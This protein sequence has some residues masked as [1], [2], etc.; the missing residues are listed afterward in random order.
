MWQNNK[1]RKRQA[2]LGDLIISIAKLCLSALLPHLT[3]H[4]FFSPTSYSLHDVDRESVQGVGDIVR[5]E[6]WEKDIHV[7]RRQKYS[8]ALRQDKGL[9]TWRTGVE[10]KVAEV[11]G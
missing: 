1:G 2:S 10:T 3:P 11:K 6:G 4:M 7:K 8:K 9:E 5:S